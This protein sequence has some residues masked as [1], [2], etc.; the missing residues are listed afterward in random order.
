MFIT[1]EPRLELPNSIFLDEKALFRS[2]LLMLACF[3]ACPVPA[4]SKEGA[5][6]QTPTAVPS[7]RLWWVSDQGQLLAN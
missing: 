2:I 5:L 7:V 1:S 4:P 6:H 3:T